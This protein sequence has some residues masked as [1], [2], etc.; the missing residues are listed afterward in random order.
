M[1]HLLNHSDESLVP[2][3]DFLC[4]VTVERVDVCDDE[5]RKRPASPKH[6]RCSRSITHA[7]YPT[8][9]LLGHRN[10]KEAEAYRFK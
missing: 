4:M 8:H 2:Q 3:M 5:F 1:A 6:G 7:S 10:C 9:P